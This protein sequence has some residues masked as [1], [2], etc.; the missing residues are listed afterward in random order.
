MAAPCSVVHLSHEALL[1]DTAMLMKRDRANM[2][3]LLI[4][5]A[6]IDARRLYAP[7]GYG[8]MFAWCMGELRMSEDEAY[9]RIQAARA[10]RRVPAICEELAAGR[11]HLTAIVKLAPHLTDENASELLAAA[12]HK[13][14]ADVELLLAERFP[15]PDMPTRL[16]ALP[17][18]GGA[19]SPA[20]VPS[21]QLVSKPV[22]AAN[23][24]GASEPVGETAS[25]LVSKPV[26]TITE[27]GG[28][29]HAAPLN[30]RC[31][32]GRA[33]ASPPAKLIPLAPA[34]FGLQFTIAQETRDKLRRALEL[35]GHQIPSGD[36]AQV[37]DRALDA[38][39]TQLEKQKFAATSKPCERPRP[40]TRRRH[41]PAHVKRHVWRRDGGQCTFVSDTGQRCSARTGLEFDHA[42][43]VARGGRSTAGNLRL[44]CRVH[45]AYEAERAFGAAFMDHK[46]REAARAAGARA[47]GATTVQRR[48]R[49]RA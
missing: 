7:A 23:G 13:S 16:R 45:N 21:D 40:T 30:G 8:S 32:P 38:L 44:R 12:V 33:G 36:V 20:A 19:P 35:L 6:E 1:R 28:A 47:H 5:L 10:A 48:Q 11:L 2:A 29:E 9:K 3:M 25:Q 18:L 22:A 14:T 39:I 41:I 24:Q 4:H 31:V 27:P 34:R 15:R 42:E 26:G 37:F 17:G 49:Y 46:R 43:P